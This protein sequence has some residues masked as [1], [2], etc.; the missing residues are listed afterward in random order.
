MILTLL[1]ITFIILLIIY[2][3]NNYNNNDNNNN[4]YKLTNILN[5]N[6]SVVLV[7]NG[8]IK[9]DDIKKINNSNY[10]VFRF[11][12]AKNINVN[13]KIDIIVLRD[14]TLNLI[15][16]YIKLNIYILPIVS[17]KNSY[18]ILK[19]YKNYNKLLKPILIYEKLHGKN[20][21]V[22]DL[23]IF[24]TYHYHSDTLYGLST[25]GALIEYLYNNF[26]LKNIYLYGFN[27]NGDNR[28]IDFKYKNLIK[29]NCKNCIINKTINS[30]YV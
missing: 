19:K 18:K 11:N 3:I 16:K 8:P 9:K 22:N 12:D 2:S 21:I 30:N 29:D 4:N 26:K 28:H 5:K 15:K 7:G 6:D 27:F 10:L 24:N 20:N 23:K 1:F 13:D 25:G 14:N 17:N